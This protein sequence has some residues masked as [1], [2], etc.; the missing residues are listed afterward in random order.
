MLGTHINFFYYSGTGNTYLAVREMTEVFSARGIKV[1][2]HK[3]EHT[4]PAKINTT[5]TIGLAFPVAF[6]STF[7][8]VW[9]FFKAL[10]Q[11]EGTLIF[12]VDTMMAF[13]GAI[14]GPLNKSLTAK[15]YRCI[16]AKEICMP[17]NW[18]PK[19]INEE[20]NKVKINKG[21]KIAR[22][23]AEDLLEGETSW[24]Q[25]PLLSDGLYKLC[26]N[27]VMINRVNLATGRRI[28]VD[29][30]RCTQ[31]GL[32]SKL[33]PKHNIIMKE[34]PEWRDSCEVCMR[35]LSF[36]PTKAVLIPGKEF[37]RY[38]AVSAKELL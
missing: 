5:E 37:S 23:Y 11:S 35:C 36:C 1:T 18:F 21:L 9:D 4:D 19:K 24:G 25:I 33:C 32:C 27:S 38:R 16:G 10:P 31:C 13:S 17:S 12:M 30:S 6:Q 14:V 29:K 26:C 8:F 34:Y 22:E 20:K 28:S 15:G 7:P 3:I 2:L